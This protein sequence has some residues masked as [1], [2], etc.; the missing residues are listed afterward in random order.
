MA[1]EGR[2]AQINEIYSLS[3]LETLKRSYNQMESKIREKE[4][5]KSVFFKMFPMT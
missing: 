5:E 4:E 2:S 1:G 3:E